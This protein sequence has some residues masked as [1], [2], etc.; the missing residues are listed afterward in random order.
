[1]SRRLIAPALFAF[2]AVAYAPDAAA[3]S[4]QDERYSCDVAWNAAIRLLHVDF[5]FPI[6]ERDRDAGFVLFTWRDPSHTSTGSMELIR[7][8][9]EGND[10]CRIVVQLAQLPNYAERMILSRLSRKLREEYGEPPAA[11]VDP[12]AAGRVQSPT[13]GRLRDDAPAEQ[14]DRPLNEPRGDGGVP[15]R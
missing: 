1:M 6:T 3:R 10:G 4:V 8:R 15:G 12:P 13:A 5:G 9:V 11:R 14:G 2:S 7:T